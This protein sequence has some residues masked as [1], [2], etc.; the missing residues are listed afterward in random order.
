MRS[1]PKSAGSAALLLLAALAFS[2]HLPSEE[3]GEVVTSL[4]FEPEA[5][6][7]FTSSASV[8]YT[9]ARPATTTLRIRAKP[10]DSPV[11]SLFENLRESKGVHSHTWLG[12]T[13]EGYFAPSGGYVGILEVEGERFE[14][15]VRIY[16]R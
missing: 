5:F 1:L 10:T 4:R 8:R 9:L 14:A 12:D 2:C 7:S 16:H 6:D 13:A 3:T 15:V 11:I